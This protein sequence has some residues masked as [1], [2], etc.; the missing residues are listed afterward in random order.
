MEGCFCSFECCMAYL[1]DHFEK[2]AEKRDPLYS[3]SITLLHQLFSI[4]AP[5]LTLKVAN[6][7]RIL[8]KVSTGKM[9]IT[10]FRSNFYHFVRTS[11]IHFASS[12]ILYQLIE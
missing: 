12:Q 10:Q 3:K 7:W 2:I 5:T 8:E 11:N 9:S 1:Y 4:I 6:D